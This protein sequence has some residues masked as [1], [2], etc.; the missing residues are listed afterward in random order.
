MTTLESQPQVATDLEP[1]VPGLIGQTNAIVAAIGNPEN[2]AWF[3]S[4]APNPSLATVSGAAQNLVTTQTAAANRGKGTVKA[5]NLA[6]RALRNYLISLAAWVQLIANNNPGKGSAVIAASGYRE[7]VVGKRT[8]PDLAAS[9][10]QP[11]A[12]VLLVGKAG[13]K[14]AR[15]FYGWRYMLPGTTTWVVLPSTND[16]HTE[17]T[18]LPA[19]AT[20]TFQYQ[21]T[22]KNVAG[23][24]SQSISF[25]V[26]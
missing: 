20:V 5:R 17:V 2:A 19:L 15:V 22:A 24:W 4:P 9:Q 8:K 11:G 14:G 6:W 25:L 21:I 23:E 12:P 10:T 26:H 7:K 18:G 3:G 16:A 1:T 13:P